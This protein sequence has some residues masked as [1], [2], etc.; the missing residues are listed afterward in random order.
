MSTSPWTCQR[1]GAA[2]SIALGLGLAAQTVSAEG[3]AEEAPATTDVAPMAESASESGVEPGSAEA[4]PIPEP[5]PELGAEAELPEGASPKAESGLSSDS[6]ATHS[7]PLTVGE[8]LL[9][10]H[11]R[12]SLELSTGDLSITGID[13]DKG[14]HFFGVNVG[15]LI[16][17]VP[18]FSFG[19]WIGTPLLALRQGAVD[20]PA[21]WSFPFIGIKAVKPRPRSRCLSSSL[22]APG[23]VARS[24][25][26]RGRVQSHH[27]YDHRRSDSAHG[28][29]PRADRPS[30][31]FSRRSIRGLRRT[32]CALRRN[33]RLCLCR[34]GRQDADA[35]GSA[36]LCLL[37]DEGRHGDL[38]PAAPRRGFARPR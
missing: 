25:D 17:V 38:H 12:N 24:V 31:R 11:E 5:A 10:F 3:G 15:Y 37:D 6:T 30:L 36:P 19:P 27:R 1:A 29:L 22:V 21:F 20:F 28:R 2:L 23:M 33:G 26:R 9:R 16:S 34:R 14:V 7:T 18:A 4:P 13:Y 32:G 8:W 35:S